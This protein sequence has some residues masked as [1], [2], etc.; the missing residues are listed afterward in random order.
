LVPDQLASLKLAF[1]NQSHC[2]MA[3]RRFIN[4]TGKHIASINP[5]HASKRFHKARLAPKHLALQREIVMLW[6][7]AT[8][9]LC[10]KQE[11]N[12]DSSLPLVTQN[13]NTG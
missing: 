6:S 12:Q 2:G 3:V 9:N 8:K 5:L 4:Q 7:E 10:F 13:D 11:K 1:S